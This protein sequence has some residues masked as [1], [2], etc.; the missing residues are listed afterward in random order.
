MPRE[1][2]KIIE[3]NSKVRQSRAKAVVA[4]SFSEEIRQPILRVDEIKFDHP[5]L[6]LL[7]DKVVSDVDMWKR[8][9]KK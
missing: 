7:R 5:I 9:L 4:K 8:I 2:L 1:C 6:N 3:S